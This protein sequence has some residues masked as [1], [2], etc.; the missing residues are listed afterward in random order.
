MRSIIWVD[1]DL[2]MDPYDQNFF[3]FNRAR[4]IFQI[5]RYVNDFYVNYGKQSQ[6]LARPDYD[7]YYL[8]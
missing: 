3:D 2:T 6:I 1:L 8:Q 4:T 5:T 7:K